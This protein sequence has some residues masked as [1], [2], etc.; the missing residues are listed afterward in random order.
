MVTLP[1]RRVHAAL[2][3]FPVRCEAGSETRVRRDGELHP[4]TVQ[5]LSSGPRCQDHFWL[6]I[7]LCLTGSWSSGS[8]DRVRSR[9]LPFRHWTRRSGRIPALPYPPA[10]P[11][12]CKP[13]ILAGSGKS[14]G[15]GDRVPESSN[16]PFLVNRRRRP[17]AQ[18]LMGPPVVVELEPLF[19]AAASFVHALVILQVHLLVFQ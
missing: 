12:Q 19:D 10:Q 15:F 2:E 9:P 6:W 3:Q 13:S 7:S 4:L 17:V 11:S 18:A 16:D 14:Q 8:G 5:V 1:G